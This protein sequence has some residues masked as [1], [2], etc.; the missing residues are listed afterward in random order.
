[1]HT[2]IYTL[3]GSFESDGYA[4][5]YL[6]FVISYAI[7][8]SFARSV[9][10]LLNQAELSCASGNRITFA[11]YNEFVIFYYYLYL[12]CSFFL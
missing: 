7:I 5:V 6:P 8:C 11:R 3:H 2:E 10:S 9:Q 1:M 12:S 4:L